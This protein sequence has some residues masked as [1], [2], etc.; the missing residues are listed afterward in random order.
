MPMPE[1]VLYWNKWTK[2]DTGTEEP[3]WNADAG[4]IDL[5]ADAL[6]FKLVL[7][8]PDQTKQFGLV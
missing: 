7:T 3:V 4:D 2:S 8:F 5:D 6:P 1:L